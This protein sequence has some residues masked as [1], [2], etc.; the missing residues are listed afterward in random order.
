MQ[1]FSRRR[2]RHWQPGPRRPRRS[3]KLGAPAHQCPRPGR[4]PPPPGRRGAG[5]QGPG[6]S[7]RVTPCRAGR[8]GGSG[9]SGSHGRR[10]RVAPASRLSLGLGVP[11]RRLVCGRQ[12]RPCQARRGASDSP[13]T[14]PPRPASGRRLGLGVLNRVASVSD[15]RLRN[16]DPAIR[17]GPAPGC[18]GCGLGAGAGGPVG[19]RPD[20]AGGA[21]RG[22]LAAEVML[23]Y[24]PRQLSMR[25]RVNNRQ[26]S[27]QCQHRG[28]L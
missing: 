17:S 10:V 12:R 25:L 9:G 21:G 8:P 20:P 28:R 22:R 11:G 13:V 26:S 14:P 15:S 6:R 23:S 4:R 5:R 19:R 27:K 1:G 24:E 2:P 3:A 18:R 16:R 7:L